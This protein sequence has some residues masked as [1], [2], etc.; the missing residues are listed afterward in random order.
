MPEYGAMTSIWI[1]IELLSPCNL[2][3]MLPSLTLLNTFIKGIG[4][5]SA[6]FVKLQLENEIHGLVLIFVHSERV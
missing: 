4:E 6:A 2:R 3:Q 5:N 1:N